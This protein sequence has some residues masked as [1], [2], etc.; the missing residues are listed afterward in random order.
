LLTFPEEE[1]VV[2]EISL[3]Q[4]GY[5]YA[6]DQGENPALACLRPSGQ[7][8]EGV[9]VAGSLQTFSRASYAGL[10]FQAL[11]K[12]LKQRTRRIGSFWVGPEAEKKLR[13]G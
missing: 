3:R 13:L 2:R 4:G 9:L 1:I 7:F 12:L 10:L 6:V 5:A 8:A 11:G